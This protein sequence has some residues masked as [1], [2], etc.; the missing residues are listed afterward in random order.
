MSDK[1]KIDFYERWLKTLDSLCPEARG[2]VNSASIP[3]TGQFIA[4]DATGLV[5]VE[6][7]KAERWKK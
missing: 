1:E 3:L 6:M 7:T 2:K 4:V 5:S